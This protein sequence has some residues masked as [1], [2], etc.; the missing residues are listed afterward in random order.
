MN[1]FADFMHKLCW[2]QFFLV[3]AA[4]PWVLIGWAIYYWAT[5]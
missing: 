3:S 1:A 5:K 4:L 2:V